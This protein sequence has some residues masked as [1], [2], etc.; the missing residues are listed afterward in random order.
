VYNTERDVWPES[1]RK[2]SLE[3]VKLWTT[4][5][6]GNEPWLS[7]AGPKK[8][9]RLGPAGECSLRTFEDDETRDY[10]YLSWTRDHFDETMRLLMSFA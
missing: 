3:M 5:A 1:A 7:Y 6:Y 2:V 9:M 10:G 8:F 4:F